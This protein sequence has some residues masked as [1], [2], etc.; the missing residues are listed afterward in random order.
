MPPLVFAGEARNLTQRLAQVVEGRGLPAPG[1]RLRRVV[2]H[3]LGRQHPRQAAGHPPDGRRADVLVGRAD[4]EGRADR[5]PVRQAPL[6]ARPRPTAP[7]SCRRSAAT[8]S[9]TSPSASRPGGP[10]PSGC[11]PPTSS[12]RPRSTCCGPSPTAASPTSAG[13]TPGTRSSWPARPRATATRRSP[14]HRQRSI[15]VHPPPYRDAFDVFKGDIVIGPVL[16]N[17]EHPRDIFVVEP[18]RR[19]SLLIKPLHDLRITRLIER[20]ELDS[21]VPIKLRIVS[22]EDRAHAPGSDRLFEEEGADQDARQRQGRRRGAGVCQGLHRRAVLL[23]E[24]TTVGGSGEEGTTWPSHA[25]SLCE[26]RLSELSKLLIGSE[27]CIDSSSSERG[28]SPKRL[29]WYAMCFA[30]TMKRDVNGD[31]HAGVARPIQDN[32]RNGACCQWTVLPSLP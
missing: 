13:C 28:P 18:G 27:I 1:R 3:V 5:R 22:P 17:A 14:T 19:P 2:R 26:I 12:P 8:S 4:R 29:P 23:E 25:G 20:Q 31:K 6:G 7:S 11:S 16:A 24:R 21:H 30:R 10:T 15:L 32:R 9:T